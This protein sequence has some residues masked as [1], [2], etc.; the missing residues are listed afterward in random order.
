MKLNE[1]LQ[2]KY[3]NLKS[4]MD[5]I[6]YGNKK[7]PHSEYISALGKIDTSGS[8]II[9][10]TSN[11]VENLNDLLQLSIVQKFLYNRSKTNILTNR[12]IALSNSK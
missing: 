7:N 8:Y 1:I 3:S 2:I 12:Q 6:F 11:Y 5:L 4:H 9:N 10:F